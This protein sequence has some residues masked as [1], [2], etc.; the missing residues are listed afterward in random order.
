MLFV[1][2]CGSLN[3]CRISV[4]IGDKYSQ[5]GEKELDKQTNLA[6]NTIIFTA[7]LSGEDDYTK[8]GDVL[9]EARRRYFLNRKKVKDKIFFTSGIDSVR[10]MYQID[11]NKP[12]KWK[13]EVNGK[14]AEFSQSDTA[15]NYTIICT[16][17]SGEISKKIYFNRNNIWQKTEYFKN[18]MLHTTLTSYKS[19]NS[20]TIAIQ[21]QGGTA[22]ILMAFSDKNAAPSAPVVSAQTSNGEYFFAALP[23]ENSKQD[24]K[25]AGDNIKRKGFFFDT[26]LMYGDFT[27]LNFKKGISGEKPKIKEQKTDDKENNDSKENTENKEIIEKTEKI[28]KIEKTED[29]EN[30]SKE[31]LTQDLKPSADDASDNEQENEVESDAKSETE[32]EPQISPLNPF[33]QANESTVKP[34]KIIE[35]SPKERYYYFGSLSK[36]GERSGSGITMSAK[37]SVIYSGGYDGDKRSGFGAQYFKN[38]RISYVGKWSED[39]KNGF[40]ISFLNDGTISA[41]SFEND[42]K[43]GVTARFTNEGKLSSVI[44][45][46]NDT[47]HGAAI[48]VDSVSGGLTVQKCDSGKMKNPVTVL[49]EHGN[50]VYNGEMIDGKFCGEGKLFD[51]NGTL[52]YSG[53]FKDNLQ[54]GTGVLY[55]DDKSF[56]SGEFL[57]GQIKGEATHRLSNGTILYKGG[58]KDGEY[59]GKGTVYKPDGSSYS[60]TFE[61][62]REK[63]AI[64]VYSKA[65]ELL[66]KGALKNGEYNGNGTLYQNGS[67][68]YEGGFVNG[69]KSG[70]G[71]I[72]RD[73]LCEYMGSFEND[74]RSGFGISYK[75]NEILY[76]GFWLNDKYNGNGVLHDT[77]N[78][79]DFAGAF[80]D[81]KMNG[82][83]NVIGNE[84]LL[85]ECLYENGKCT[86]MRE[87]DESGS[88]IYEGSVVGYAREGMGCSYTKYGEKLFEGI[89]KYG[90]PYKAMRVIPKQLDELEF[91]DKLKD[92]PYNNYRK[93]PVFVSEQF[94]GKGIYSGSLKDGKPCGN[95]TMLYTDHRYTGEFKNGNPCGSGVLYFGDGK[96]ISGEF[97][98]KQAEDSSAIEFADAVYYLKYENG[99][100]D[101]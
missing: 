76:S 16:D 26:S 36:N 63:G 4:F 66:Y 10:C 21:Q 14:L 58:F 54:N 84:I 82:R 93:P 22:Q 7:Y 97:F 41:G 53:E 51:K 9:L 13:K 64:S 3:Y 24:K 40:G 87:Y 86:Y 33:N 62:G 19:G 71:R 61:N 43:K 31:P 78:N 38:G 94:L 85:K 55:L 69:K 49:D 17:I 81:G 39:K 35:N 57:N 88:V 79:L 12:M 96:E 29:D 32:S 101:E 65:G 28:E 52:K 100:D 90:E 98:E 95:G 59:S 42:R 44:S 56:I 67:K 73:N 20:L 72:Y 6:E 37:G 11:S 30:I 91:C 80:A 23:E 75:N 92:T 34:D 74:T 5:K 25:L 8:N 50:I 89:F 77:E 99:G 2:L 48:I 83:I 1:I 27:T 45:Y 46:Q 15:G 18:A 70:L 60:A 47:V 68:I